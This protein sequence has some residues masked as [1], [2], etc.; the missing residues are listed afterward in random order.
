MNGF[1]PVVRNGRLNERIDAIIV[2]IDEMPMN[3]GL[4]DM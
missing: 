2:G 4:F 3:R 1:E